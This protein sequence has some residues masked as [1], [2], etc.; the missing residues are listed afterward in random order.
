[1]MRDVSFLYMTK[2]AEDE[3][4][5]KETVSAPAQVP[6]KPEAPL[7]PNGI[8]SYIMPGGLSLLSA[9]LLGL[10][11]NA[12]G[13][14]QGGLAGMLTGAIGGWLGGR[15]LQNNPDAAR[16]LYDMGWKYP[17]KRYNALRDQQVGEKANEIA[18]EKPK[19]SAQ[20]P[21]GIERK[22]ARPGFWSQAK[23]TYRYMWPWN[24]GK[25]TLQEDIEKTVNKAE[26]PYVDA[27]KQYQ[28]DWQNTMDAAR[29]QA[30]E[31]IP[32]PLKDLR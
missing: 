18:G 26:Q 14:K 31:S 2:L 9:L 12:A 15:Y 11:G 17:A 22:N 20:A 1:M 23:D 4:P 7:N 8:E 25:S 3:T 24:W 28:E 32:D 13:G 19:F 10:I 30:E 21:R 6:S 16:W 5:P 27:Y 29:Q